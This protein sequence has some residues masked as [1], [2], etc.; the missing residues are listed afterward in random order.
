MERTGPVLWFD[1]LESTNNRMKELIRQGAVHGTVLAAREQTGGRGR[2]GRSFASPPGG[3]Y[4]SLLLQ[5]DC[6]PERCLSLTPLAAVA[7]RRAV[8]ACADAEPVI[9][10]PNDLLLNGK[11]LCG[12]LVELL[13]AGGQPQVIVGIG[14]N[15]NTE[16]EEFPEELRETACSLY[17][18]TGRRIELHVL[19]ERLIGEL[20]GLYAAWL[21]DARCCLAEYRAACATVGREV[22]L[23]QNGESRAALAL[24]VNEEY[25]LTVQ[26][27]DGSTEDIRFGEVSVRSTEA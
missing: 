3:L 22:L 26:Y 1:T 27:P 8:A 10:W 9:K 18:E 16:R 5:P 4:L 6:A 21:A 12:I 15:V 2:L 25:S 19:A 20:D 13:F 14:V 23:L 7:V 11:K 17:T 24:G